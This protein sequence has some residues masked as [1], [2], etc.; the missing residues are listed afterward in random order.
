MPLMRHQ[1]EGVEF[2]L[3]NGSGIVAFEQGLGKT[4][5]AI[6][7]V[8][9]LMD[10]GSVSCAAVLCP[11]SLKRTWADELARF[12][13]HASVLVV[14]G[15][16]ATRRAQLAE[17]TATFVLL[18][19]ESA[20]NDITSVQALLARR[21]TALVLDESH[22]VKNQRSLSSVA[23]RHF[24]PLAPHR[25]LLTGTPITNRAVDIST[26]RSI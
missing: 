26:H 16:K 6:E 20:R 7:T 9:R 4:L 13:P 23:A 2:L 22:F 19:Y 3:R 18:N 25:I 24:A 15:S 17:T 1:K 10:R 14:E 21:A 5:V 12:A 11:N 8:I